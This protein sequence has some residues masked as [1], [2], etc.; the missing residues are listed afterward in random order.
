[1]VIKQ[2]KV[3]SHHKKSCQ[4]HFFLLSTLHEIYYC[5]HLLEVG[6]DQLVGDKPIMIRYQCM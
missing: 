2:K 1:M 4:F 6:Y 3:M 5:P